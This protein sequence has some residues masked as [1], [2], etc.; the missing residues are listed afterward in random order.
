M[1]TSAP[2]PPVSDWDRRDRVV[3]R[4]VHRVGRTQFGGELKLAI[5]D[6]D[7]DDPGRAGKARTPRWPLRR[8]HHSR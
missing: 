5:V 6:V 3:G 8:R 2:K 1:T 7:G 4:R